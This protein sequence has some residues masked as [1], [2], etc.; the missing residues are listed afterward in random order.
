MRGI[1]KSADS[2][3]SHSIKD[4]MSMQSDSSSGSDSDASVPSMLLRNFPTILVTGGAGFVGSH[5]AHKLLLDGHR[6][7][8]IDELNDYY[9]ISIKLENLALLRSTASDVYGDSSLFQF[10]HGDVC[11]RQLMEKIIEQEHIDAIIHLA[12]RA[13][14]RASIEIPDEYVKSNLGASTIVFDIARKY[15]IRH[16]VYASSSSVYGANKK[17]PFSELDSTNN[18]VSP[19]AAT[20]LACEAMAT[21][22]ASMF[23]YHITGLRFFTVYGPRGRP[24]MAPFKFVDRIARGKS[25]DQYGDGSSSRDYTYVSDIVDGIIAA[26]G[27]PFDKQGHVKTSAPLHT[28]YNLGNSNPVTLL[29][30]INTIENAVGK[31][32]IIKRKPMQMGDVDRT[33]ADLTKSHNELGYSPKVSLDQGMSHLVEWW[34]S[35]YG[36]SI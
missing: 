5:T 6:V 11:D 25:I 17:V 27:R 14:V 8:V 33:Y 24:D 26:L 21:A 3:V 7:V 20:K 9:D 22:Y 4:S 13:G 29:Q 30:F 19:Y 31:N 12:A 23:K 35:H 1:I 10:Y 36:D 2:A 28:V 34:R 16:V 15:N 18:V 32:A